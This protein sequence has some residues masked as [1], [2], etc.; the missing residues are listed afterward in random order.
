MD[1]CVMKNNFFFFFFHE[2]YC[3]KLTYVTFFI[4]V[5]LQPV[6]FFMQ[7]KGLCQININLEA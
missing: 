2:F 4:P 6:E 5:D 7:E 3:F 1:I